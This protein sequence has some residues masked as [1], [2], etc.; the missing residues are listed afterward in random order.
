[1]TRKTHID[2]HNRCLLLLLLVI[3]GATLSLGTSRQL[4]V[5]SL[6]LLERLFEEVGI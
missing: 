3:I 6:S 2:G 1:L 5:G 4:G